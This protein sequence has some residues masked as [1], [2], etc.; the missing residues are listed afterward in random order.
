[1]RTATKQ[2][3]AERHGIIRHFPAH[4][5]A[6]ARIENESRVVDRI[7]N[8]VEIHPTAHVCDTRRS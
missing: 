5:A 3:A 1:M 7:K 4:A 6:H 8:A 2:Q